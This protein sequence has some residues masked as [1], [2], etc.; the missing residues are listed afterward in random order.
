MR[1]EQSKLQQSAIYRKRDIPEPDR[2]WTCSRACR[3]VF[4]NLLQQS[5]QA[6]GGTIAVVRSGMRFLHH[7]MDGPVCQT[8]AVLAP[9]AMHSL[10]RQDR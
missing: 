8:Q 4:H 6:A 5:E 10:H 9:R 7:Q 2:A 1:Q 3:A